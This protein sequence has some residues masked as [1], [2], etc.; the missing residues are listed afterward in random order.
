MLFSDSPFFVLVVGGPY[1]I[2]RQALSPGGVSNRLAGC[3]VSRSL[4]FYGKPF[5][6]LIWIS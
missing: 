3:R 1:W 2:F 4:N 5:A 6:L